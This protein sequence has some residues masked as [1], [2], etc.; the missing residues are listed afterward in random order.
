[1]GVITDTSGLSDEVMQ[2]TST[3]LGYSETVFVDWRDGGS[4]RTRI[5]TPGGEVPFAGHPLVG[6]AWVL[7]V[8]GP[9][10]VDALDCPGG[11]VAI[12]ADDD[13]VFIEAPRARRTVH[14]S[15]LGPL[16]G[17]VEPVSVDRVSIPRDYLLVEVIDRRSVAA[18]PQPST[19]HTLLWCWDGANIK[20]RF[21]APDLK[22]PEDAATGAGAIA[23]SALLRSRGMTSGDLLMRQGDEIGA[24]SEIMLRWEDDRAWVGGT[25]VHRHTRVL[26]V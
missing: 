4:P 6:A 25:V 23:L 16:D 22:V 12:E 11:T 13:R 8:L 1:M 19:G 17:W 3:D 18:A 2:I 9:G 26:D 14:S 20:A 15:E 24:P 5:F 21:F 7:N 10:G